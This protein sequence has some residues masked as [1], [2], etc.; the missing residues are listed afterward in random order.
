MSISETKTSTTHLEHK[1]YK[2]T[3]TSEEMLE[4]PAYPLASSDEF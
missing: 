4:R 3:L 1:E 2:E